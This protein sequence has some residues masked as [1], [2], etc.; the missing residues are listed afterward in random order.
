[1]YER[2][3]SPPDTT[4]RVV[5]QP[6]EFGGDGLALFWKNGAML[7]G[8]ALDTSV[9]PL[10]KSGGGDGHWYVPMCGLGPTPLY[11]EYSE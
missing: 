8:F 2:D 6:A 9:P 3:K 1:M 4:V 7:I 10:V 5:T 11:S